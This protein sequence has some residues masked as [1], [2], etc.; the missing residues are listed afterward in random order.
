MNIVPAL[1]VIGQKAQ[2][3][4]QVTRS[5]VGEDGMLQVRLCQDRQVLLAAQEPLVGLPDLLHRR[6]HLG[7]TDFCFCPEESSLQEPEKVAPTPARPFDQIV[8]LVDARKKFPR[9]ALVY[10]FPYSF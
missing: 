1:A 5:F 7:R 4:Q 2:V 10:G 6:L 8:H 3:M 9:H